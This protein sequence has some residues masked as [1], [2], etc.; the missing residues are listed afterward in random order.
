MDGCRFIFCAFGVSHHRYPLRYRPQ[1]T[2]G[3]EFLCATITE[4][5]S[6]LLWCVASVSLPDT[7]PWSALETRSFTLF[8]LSFQYDAYAHSGPF[9]SWGSDDGWSSVVFSSRRTVLLI[10]AFCRLACWAKNK[11]NKNFHCNYGRRAHTSGCFG[12]TWRIVW[13][14]LSYPANTDRH[15]RLWRHCGTPGARSFAPEVAHKKSFICVR[16]FGYRSLGCYGFLG[17]RTSAP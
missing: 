1:T 12:L 3:Q 13:L 15:S 7:D 10:M 9:I 11:A 6:S 14:H 5:F 4:N 16:N 8:L 17:T 2:S